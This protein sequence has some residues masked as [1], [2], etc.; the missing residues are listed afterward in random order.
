[1]E[2]GRDDEV[3]AGRDGDTEVGRQGET[4]ISGIDGASGETEARM[5]GEMGNWRHEG[6]VVGKLIHSRKKRRGN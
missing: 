2:L 6:N 4:G 1:M 3:E 5:H